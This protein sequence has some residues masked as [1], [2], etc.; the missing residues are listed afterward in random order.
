MNHADFGLG[1]GIRKVV[2]MQ[3][4]LGMVKLGQRIRR[5]ISCE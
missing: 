2:S 3:F 4:A 5:R 1:T